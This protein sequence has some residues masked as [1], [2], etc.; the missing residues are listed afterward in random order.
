MHCKTNLVEMT[1]L[2]LSKE[3]QLKEEAIQAA[4][5]ALIKLM[6][7]LS[8]QPTGGAVNAGYKDRFTDFINDDLD[9]PKALALTWDLM[10]DDAISAAD[11]RATVLDFDKVFGLNLADF[12]ATAEDDAPAEVIALAEAREIARKEK[13]WIKAD[14]LRK[15]ISERGFE[16]KDME[17]E[18]KI[19]HKNQ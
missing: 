13:D 7:A 1:Y 2:T 18:F 6:T 3:E 11:K 14:A 17:G 9:L 8:E 4:Q 12:K 19:T 15:E 5:N 16:V 10:K